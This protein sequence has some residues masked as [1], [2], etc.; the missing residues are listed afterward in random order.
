MG[1]GIYTWDRCCKKRQC[2]RRWLFI[3]NTYAQ[4]ALSIFEWRCLWWLEVFGITGW[5]AQASVIG[6]A[7][8]HIVCHAPQRFSLPC[9]L[10]MADNPQFGEAIDLQSEG[11]CSDAAGL[12]E[13]SEIPRILHIPPEVFALVMSFL[14][15]KFRKS[16]RLHWV[17]YCHWRASGGVLHNHGLL[18]IFWYNQGIYCLFGNHSGKNSVNPMSN[19]EMRLS[20]FWQVSW[21][22]IAKSKMNYGDRRWVMKGLGSSKPYESDWGMDK[23]LKGYIGCGISRVQSWGIWIM[24]GKRG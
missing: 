19:W 9:L 18:W 3:G 24:D 21:R 5:S 7:C 22:H 14:P 15:T 10:H 12:I 13:L 1:F 2:W 6:F 17:E 20:I 4:S 8:S 23:T 16:K 11:K